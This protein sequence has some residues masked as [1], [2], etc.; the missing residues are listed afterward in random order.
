MVA[1]FS[2]LRPL[3][4]LGKASLLRYESRRYLYPQDLEK[5]IQDA[6]S[7]SNGYAVGG[8]FAG[9]AA[10]FNP[11]NGDFIPIPEHMVPDALLDW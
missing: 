11:G 2:G 6:T 1:A 3:T 10:T 4:V 5:M 9:L 8:D 7:S